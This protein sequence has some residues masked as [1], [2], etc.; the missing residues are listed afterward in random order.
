MVIMMA[1]TTI[2]ARLVQLEAQVSELQAEVK[3]LRSDRDKDWR[4]AVAKFAGDKDIRSLLEG[5]QRL[6]ESD[7]KPCSDSS[8]IPGESTK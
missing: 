5:A 4:R 1:S 7:R 8:D 3:R 6:R 2:E